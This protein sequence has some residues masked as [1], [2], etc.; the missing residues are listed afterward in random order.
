M[1]D[2]V[3][4]NGNMDTQYNKT[5]DINYQI[6]YFVTNHELEV[7]CPFKVVV[8]SPTWSYALKK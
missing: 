1:W 2:G 7:S 3:E 6:R 8:F 4:N 5:L